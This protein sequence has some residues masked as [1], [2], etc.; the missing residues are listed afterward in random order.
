MLEE[1]RGLSGQ[2]SHQIA[3]RAR[4]IDVSSL[5]SLVKRGP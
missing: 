2:Y 4:T 5:A 1:A 3:E